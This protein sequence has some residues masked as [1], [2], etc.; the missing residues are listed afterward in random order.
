MN[1][2]RKIILTVVTAFCLVFSFNSI[3]GP[4]NLLADDDDPTKSKVAAPPNMMEVSTTLGG[5]Y[6]VNKALIQKS[7]LLQNQLSNVRD[8]IRAGEISSATAMERLAS[9]E[10]KLQLV[11]A[12]I[13]EQKILVSA[14]NVYTKTV[15]EIFD[16][17]EEKLVILTGDKVRIRGWQGPG[18]K[19]VLEKT[20]VAKEQPDEEAFAQIQVEHQLDSAESIVGET[21]EKREL[22]EREFLASEDGQQMTEAQLASRRAL[23]ES[24]NA[25][26]TKYKPFQ[27]KRCNILGVKGLTFQ[28]GNK[29]LS[30]EIMSEGG[31]GFHSSKWQRHAT[32]TVYLPVCNWVAVRGCKVGVDILGVE[33]NLLLTG[34][35]SR[36]RD[37]EGSF[38]VGNIKG[39]VVIDQAPIRKL[40]KISGNIEFVATDEF[41][42]SGTTHEGGTRTAHSFDTQAT[43][44]RDVDGNLSAWFLRTHLSLQGIAG[45]IDVRNEFGDTE[46]SLDKS[47]DCETTHRI[48][49][50]NG[51]IDVTGSNRLLEKLSIYAHTLCGTLFTNLN[52]DILD[53]VSFSTGQP[54][55]N[56]SGFVTPS[57]DRFSM[58]KFERPADALANKQRSA[59]IDLISKTGSVKV[60]A[61]N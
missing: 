5:A 18:I 42:N 11:R 3:T 6:F 8:Q 25:S 54:R 16:L 55:R 43:E 29:N 56:W 19:C 26:K 7:K 60:V 28:E 22:S 2:N 12:S 9:I 37:Y 39:D 38:E 46:L 34:N 23:I 24:I 58:S 47:F 4:L 32:L 59:G 61:E 21:F 14:F 20:I 41:V 1:I 27:G 50:E 10:T 30:L 36:D 31:G 52:R 53:D 45:I 57:Q 40:F 13:E 44:I 49:S 51:T 35:G 33:S 48:V 15:E 17:G